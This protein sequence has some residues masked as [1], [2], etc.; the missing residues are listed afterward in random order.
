[1]NRKAVCGL[2]LLSVVLAV[3]AL[4]ATVPN[5]IRGEV[6]VQG[7]G[8]VPLSEG[9]LAGTQGESRRL[10]GFH[11]SLHPVLRG[12]IQYMCHIQNYGDTPWLPTGT[13]CGTRGQS[14]RMEGFAVRLTGVMAQ[15]YDVKYQCHLQGFGDSDVMQNGQF[16]GTRGQALRLEAMRVW[17]E[18]K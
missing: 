10:E 4:A 3:P 6:H 9:S 12:S 11:L 1:M 8:D 2:G 14:R 18:P 5:A 16:C 17:L 7:M 15:Y 13:F